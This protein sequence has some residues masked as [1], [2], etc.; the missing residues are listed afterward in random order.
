M[1]KKK[2]E[3]TMGKSLCS[4]DYFDAGAKT[5]CFVCDDCI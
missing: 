4:R 1:K 2:D 5:A 3:N